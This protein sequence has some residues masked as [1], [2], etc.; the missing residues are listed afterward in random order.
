MDEAQ[1]EEKSKL[2]TNYSVICPLLGWRRRRG[3]EEEE[4]GQREEERKNPGEQEG[5]ERKEL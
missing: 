2:S 1:C 4:G 3:E 5:E